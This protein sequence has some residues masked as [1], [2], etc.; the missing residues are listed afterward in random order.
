MQRLPESASRICFAEGA[1]FSRRS[2]VAATIIP[3]VQKPHCIAWV[4]QKACWRGRRPS[5]G[6]RPSMVVTLAPSSCTAKRRQLRALAPSTKTV[7]A[8]Q[9][10]CS[11]P[12]WVPVSPRYCR[13]KSASAWRTA[14]SRSTAP[15]LTVRRIERRAVGAERA[16]AEANITSPGL[17]EAA[18]LVEVGGVSLAVAE[19]APQPIPDEGARPQED[20]AEEEP[21]SP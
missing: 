18:E 17:R 10:P 15:P 13:R 8:P 11:Q 3:G 21:A 14:T 12:T 20:Q 16:M 5:G 19:P 2:S 1:G 6:V 4:S 7:Q 9:T